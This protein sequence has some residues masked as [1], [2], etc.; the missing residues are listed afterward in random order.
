MADR[1][2]KAGVGESHSPDPR[3]L[4][5]RFAVHGVFEAGGGGVLVTGVV[6][7]GTVKRGMRFRLWRR[8]TGEL[9]RPAITAV[10]IRRSLRHRLSAKT[11]ANPT[12]EIGEAH[13]GPELLGVAVI[14]LEPDDGG[15]GDYLIGD[16]ES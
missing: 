4:G 13:A 14:G 16:L 6:E 11:H 15:P 3:I 2:P 5:P 8:E 9:G 10:T 12:E 7:S 1:P